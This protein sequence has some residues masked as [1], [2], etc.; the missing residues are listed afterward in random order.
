[1]TEATMATI[2]ESVPKLD[3]VTPGEMLK[4]AR[5]KS[6]VTLEAIGKELN[7]ATS[8]LESLEKDQYEK[9]ASNVFAVGYLRRYAK[10][11]GVDEQAIV[12]SFNRYIAQMQATIDE[13]T[14]EPEVS[15]ASLIPPKLLMPAVVFGVALLVIISVIFFA[16]GGDEPAAGQ[17]P[18]VAIP[19]DAVIESIADDGIETNN[20]ATA[21]TPPELA[22]PVLTNETQT[23]QPVD[24]VE[25][26]PTT[27][28][29]PV[30]VNAASN[31]APSSQGDEPLVMPEPV[32]VASSRGPS[33]EVIKMGSLAFSFIEDCWLKI[34]DGKGTVVH[35]QL[36]R[37]GSSMTVSAL[38]PIEV[39]VGN[40]RA[41]S[42]S[43]NGE[44]V[45]INAVPGQDTAKLTLN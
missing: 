3:F 42:L 34:T 17:A 28:E 15:N 30:T 18:A 4:K 29:S 22:Q 26:T 32:P 2:N 40:A 1:M 37:A 12:Q 21:A 27:V 10:L 14:P 16:Q 25:T 23:A 20:F 41:V 43:F 8:K 13:I 36:E 9:L 19:A 7:I 5:E 11:V 31:A 44:V 35:A 33:D 6:G 39:L 38:P 45:P 24:R